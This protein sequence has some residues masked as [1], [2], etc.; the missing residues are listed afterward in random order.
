MSRL[1]LDAVTT[2]SLSCRATKSPY[3]IHAPTYI[4]TRNK[5]QCSKYSLTQ[6]ALFLSRR[7]PER[8]EKENAERAG[9]WR[10]QT[11][12]IVELH[13]F[14]PQC[15]S[16]AYVLRVG[17]SQRFVAT[18][19]VSHSE[20]DRGESSSASRSGNWNAPRRCRRRRKPG[21]R[22][23]IAA[24]SRASGLSRLYVRQPTPVRCNC[25][26][27]RRTLLARHRTCVYTRLQN[28]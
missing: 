7:R 19:V 18:D 3:H 21:G 10:V 2:A 11:Q 14:K 24:G 4:C 12:D 25:I 20:A 23:E 26:D 13:T 9:A 1:S 28:M 6:M 27:P 22:G 16:I 15:N 8:L 17:T 5:V